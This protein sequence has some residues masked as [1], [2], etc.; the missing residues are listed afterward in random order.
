MTLPAFR[1]LRPSSVEEAARLLADAGPEAM[2]IAGGTDVVPNLQMRLVAPRFLVDVKGLEE[3]RGIGFDEREGLRLGALATLAEIAASADVGRRF[4]VLTAAARTVAGPLQR[5][6]GTLG[7]NLCLET[8]C[9]WYNQSEFWRASLGGCLKKD[10]DV[11]HVAPGGRRCWAV[12]SGDMAPALLTLEAELEIAGPGGRRRIPL[13]KFYRNDGLD[14]MALEAGELV[15]A[16]RVVPAAAFRRGAYRKLRVRDSID[17]P[18]A[19]VAVAMTIDGEGICRAARLALGA[20][21]PAPR[22]VPAAGKRLEGKRY[23]PEL[24]EEVAQETIRVAKPLT[25]SASTP[26]YRRDM[27]RLYARRALEDLWRE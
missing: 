9:V 25:T 17:Y 27:V 10:G 7:G 20:V 23:S 11:C 18:L 5:N 8:R 16:V 4:P 21:N 1:V 26:V 24:I 3:L 19:G 13:E 6:M 2:V 15:V 22:L 14:R 12:W